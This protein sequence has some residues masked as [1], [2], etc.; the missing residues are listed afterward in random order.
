MTEYF[1]M[2]IQI[3]KLSLAALENTHTSGLLQQLLN[4]VYRDDILIQLNA[5]EMLSDLTMV[6]H[7]LIY[8]DQQGIVG[9][10]ENMMEDLESNPYGNLLLPGVKTKNLVTQTKMIALT[11]QMETFSPLV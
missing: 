9:K 3:C 5:I 6:D 10:L 4:E 8:L 11:Q 1:Q 2:L 7:G